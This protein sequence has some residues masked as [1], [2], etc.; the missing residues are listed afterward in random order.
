M[1]GSSPPIETEAAR[2]CRVVMAGGASPPSA[3]SLLGRVIEAERFNDRR[4]FGE[5]GFDLHGEIGRRAAKRLRA[6][7][8]ERS[9]QPW[10]LQAPIDCRVQRGDDRLRR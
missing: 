8:G 6:Q 4:P 3:K 2:V 1:Y 5:I 7:I 9:Q 10:R